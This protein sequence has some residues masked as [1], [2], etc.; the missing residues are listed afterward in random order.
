MD[1]DLIT[2]ITTIKDLNILCDTI[3]FNKCFIEAYHKT[4]K[5]TEEIQ[6]N[7]PILEGRQWT[8]LLKHRLKDNEYILHLTEICKSEIVSVKSLKQG[9][10][11]IPAIFVEGEPVVVVRVCFGTGILKCQMDGSIFTT[12]ELLISHKDFKVCNAQFNW[13]LCIPNNQPLE[14]KES[15]MKDEPKVKLAIGKN[16]ELY[17]YRKRPDD[18][19]L[20]FNLPIHSENITLGSESL[21][22]LVEIFKDKHK[23]FLRRP[24]VNTGHWVDVALL[25]ARTAILYDRDNISFND[26]IISLSLRKS[27]PTRIADIKAEILFD[28]YAASLLAEEGHFLIGNTGTLGDCASGIGKLQ[29]LTMAIASKVYTRYLQTCES[30]QC[31]LDGLQLYKGASSAM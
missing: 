20:V 25:L 17:G 23:V 19:T 4:L 3:E 5:M 16:W 14:P 21:E 11:L 31:I 15:S 7:L 8:P 6:C 29:S 1:K 22:T 18:Y 24:H 26:G 28:G 30:V 2:E 13:K 27:E 12:N 10:I 9:D